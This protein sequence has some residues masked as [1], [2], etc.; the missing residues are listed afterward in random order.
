MPRAYAVAHRLNDLRA[1]VPVVGCWR[2]L[3]RFASSS[4][5]CAHRNYALSPYLGLVLIMSL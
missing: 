3:G 1:D 4:S 5:A 2:A